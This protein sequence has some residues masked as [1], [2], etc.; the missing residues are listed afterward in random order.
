MTYKQYIKALKA[1]VARQEFNFDPD[2]R[3]ENASIPAERIKMIRYS[4]IKSPFDVTS[5]SNLID[6]IAL[7]VF[8]G[9]VV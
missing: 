1:V 5:E 8:R 6:N 3:D 7:T 9:G 2:L 4:K